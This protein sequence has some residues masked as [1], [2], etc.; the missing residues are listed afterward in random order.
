M[1]GKRVQGSGFRVQGSGFYLVPKPELGN[2]VRL[3]TR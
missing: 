1:A 2:Q 3:G